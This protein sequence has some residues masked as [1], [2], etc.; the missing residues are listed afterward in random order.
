MF[1]FNMLPNTD[2]T[3]RLLVEILT[4][5]SQESGNLPSS[6]K[7]LRNKVI[8]LKKAIQAATGWDRDPTSL[9]NLIENS[10]TEIETRE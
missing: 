9:L 8:K 10:F 4:N 3:R 1:I 7:S 6:L 5:E 2:I